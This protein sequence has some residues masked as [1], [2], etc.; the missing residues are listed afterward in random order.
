MEIQL[1]DKRLEKIGLEN[2][3]PE[4]ASGPSKHACLFDT[5]ANFPPRF[6]QSWRAIVTESKYYED[7][8][9][10]Q[11][12]SLRGAKGRAEGQEKTNNGALQNHQQPS[13]YIVQQQR[14][15]F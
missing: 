9:Y 1:S 15:Q 10:R 12:S 4:I 5:E 14:L 7:L 13:E 11:Y 6:P 8:R 2:I 3:I